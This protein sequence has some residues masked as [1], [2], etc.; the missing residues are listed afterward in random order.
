MVHLCYGYI[1]YEYCICGAIDESEN[2]NEC[3]KFT[4][5]IDEVEVNNNNMYTSNHSA[6][7]HCFAM[8]AVWAK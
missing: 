6:Y 3:E 2:S 8:L 5:L 4:S 7:I 1:L